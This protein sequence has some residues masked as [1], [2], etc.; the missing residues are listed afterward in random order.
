MDSARAAAEACMDAL[1][2]GDEAAYLACFAPDG[3]QSGPLAGEGL[4]G[5]V[6]LKAL[7]RNLRA[8]LAPCRFLP[9]AY[10]SRGREAAMAWTCEARPGGTELRFEGISDLAFT[11][12]GQIAWAQI[13]W[14]PAFIL[15]AKAGRPLQPA[16]TPA[17]AL[18]WMKAL[19][20]QDAAE[21]R[22]LF[23]PEA[24]LTGMFTGGP[25]RGAAVVARHM[26]HAR[27][28]I[29]DPAFQLQAAFASG[30]R[31]AL[32]WTAEGAG[33]TFGGISFLDSR[34]GHHVDRARM[35]W[36]P[37]EGVG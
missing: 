15:A 4:R 29:G 10:Y 32:R 3:G 28:Q 19:E 13:F 35:F 21:L 6:A 11:V 18:A 9:T 12:L 2:A 31:L 33:R 23:S 27:R 22:A 20:A 24:E 7:F 14:N 26:A 17:L 5:A 30:G 8:E 16:G 25:L 36:D 37:A 34:D 1:N